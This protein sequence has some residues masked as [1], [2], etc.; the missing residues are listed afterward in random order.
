MSS[1]K[2]RYL[3]RVEA[4]TRGYLKVSSTHKVFKT[5]NGAWNYIERMN[6]KHPECECFIAPLTP[7]K[8]RQFKLDLS[9]TTGPDGLDF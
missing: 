7:A 9:E 6:K 3:V 1:S 5:E 8:N 4:A 2:L